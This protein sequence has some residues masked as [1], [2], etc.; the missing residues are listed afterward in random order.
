MIYKDKGGIFIKKIWSLNDMIDK[1]EHTIIRQVGM[2]LTKE[3]VIEEIAREIDLDIALLQYDNDIISYIKN[4]ENIGFFD[5]F[6]YMYEGDKKIRVRCNVRQYGQET[7]K[8]IFITK[9][10]TNEEFTIKDK[11]ALGLIATF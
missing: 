8:K 1:R 10:E 6:S 3:Q 5:F 11:L 4:V 7:T 2:I 9:S